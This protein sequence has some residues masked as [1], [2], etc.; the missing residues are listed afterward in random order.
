MA[1]PV[2]VIARTCPPTGLQAI[3]DR[4]HCAGAPGT[5]QFLAKVLIIGRSVSRDK[6][7][8]VEASMILSTRN[9]TIANLVCRESLIVD[10]IVGLGSWLGC[11]ELDMRRL[12]T[13]WIIHRSR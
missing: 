2:H 13:A 1:N 8:L 9:V 4:V 5:I 10:E 12:W 7:N 11:I 3:H 6:L